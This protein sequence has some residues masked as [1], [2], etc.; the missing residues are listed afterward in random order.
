V[1]TTEDEQLRGF[2][3]TCSTKRI[4]A[5][6]SM[7]R[8]LRREAHW[9]CKVLVDDD[10]AFQNLAIAWVALGIGAPWA[11]FLLRDRSERASPDSVRA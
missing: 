1:P 4:D 7:R 6:T 11:L 9:R 10:A 3:V 8:L 2:C 5:R